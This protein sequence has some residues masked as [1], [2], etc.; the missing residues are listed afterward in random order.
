[1]INLSHS[2]GDRA[3]LTLVAL[4]CLPIALAGCGGG[5]PKE[6]TPAVASNTAE[7]Q[8][9]DETLPP[10]P[11]FET[12]LPENLR[13]SVG[14]PFLG[15]LDAMVKRRVIRVGVTFNRTSYF[16]DK[17][18]QRGAIYDYSRVL[19]EQI[20]TKFNTGNMKVFVVLM[21]L[22]ARRCSSGRCSR[23]RSTWWPPRSP[24]GRNCRSSSISRIPRAKTSARSRSRGRAAGHGLGGRLV[25]P[26]G[27]RAQVGSSYYESL[28]AL[29]KT[30]KAKG[31]PPVNI[32]AAP[33]NLED[34]DLLEMVN[35]GLI[36]AII[37]DN[38]LGQLLEEGLSEPGDPRQP[39]PCA[40]AASR[41]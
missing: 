15:D 9:A 12:T 5:T 7:G 33:E 24:F 29:N 41:P 13:E 30:L 37:V 25:G 8:K 36:P 40:R 26:R 38:Y 32:Q 34:D 18:V 16:V 19:E 21:P 3:R 10:P 4:L 23:D 28:V 2:A 31:K 27:V 22:P 14:R 35:A 11:A 39:S 6:K 1:M 17:G 20:N